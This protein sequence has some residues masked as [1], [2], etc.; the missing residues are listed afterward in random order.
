VKQGQTAQVNLTIASTNGFTTS[1][2][3]NTTTTLPL[4]YTCTSSPAISLSNC[5]FSPTSPNQSTAV[6]VSISTTAPTNAQARPFDHG[7][8]IFYA[9]LFP[10]LFGIVF[11]AGPRRRSL[12]GIRMLGLI[13]VLGASTL[14]LGSCGG[15]NNSSSGT[16][17]TPTGNYTVTINATTGGSG[18]I[19][20]SYQFTLTVTQ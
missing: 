15:S 18:P 17:G 14:W 20:S 12:R 7:T 11:I 9:A 10:G 4:T 8:R 1:S 5:T 6:T 19:A 3:G 16:P 2:G 13:V